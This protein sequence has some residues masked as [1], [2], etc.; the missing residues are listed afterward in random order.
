M[1]DRNRTQADD[2]QEVHKANFFKALEQLLIIQLA[3]NM[4]GRPA[5]DLTPAK[6]IQ[7]LQTMTADRPDNEELN[8][9]A[10]DVTTLL[11]NKITMEQFEYLRQLEAAGNLEEKVLSIAEKIE[12]QIQTARPDREGTQDYS[13]MA[14]TAKSAEL[15]NTVRET[16]R[17]IA[18]KLQERTEKTLQP[19]KTIQ[20]NQ[21]AIIDHVSSIQKSISE[22]IAKS[23]AIKTFKAAAQAA[24]KS[25][26]IMQAAAQG[27]KAIQ[28]AAKGAAAMQEVGKNVSETIQAV[29]ERTQAIRDAQE[30]AREIL[31]AVSEFINSEKY[32]TLKQN[33][34]AISDYIAEHKT[35]LAALADAGP[36]IQELVPFL[37]L[38][39]ET[40]QE[41]N[42]ELLNYTV[43]DILEQGIDA[44]GN[45]TESPF[46]NIIERAKQS[47]KEYRAAEETVTEVEKAAE[48]LP[49]IVANPT[50]SLNLP[51]DKPNSLIWNLI[52]DSAKDNPDG[53]IKLAIDTS[54]T[55]SKQ[56]AVI[57]Y[58]LSFDELPTDVKI[59]KRLTLFDKRAYMAAAALYDAGNEIITATQVYKLMG[60][61]TPPNTTDLQKVNDSLTKMGA[62]RLYIDN[63]KEVQIHKRYM[64]FK[65]DAP[66]LP[67]ERI[68]AY[69][70]GQLTESAIRLF[71]EPP[72]ISFAKQRDQ[73]TP[74]SRE[75]LESPINKTDANMQIDDYLLV[76]IGHM[77]SG[78]GKAPRKML[79]S[80]IYDRCNIKT[81]KQ[82]QRAPQKIRVYLDHYKKC[83]WIKGY[84]EGK[85]GITIQL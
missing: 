82:K 23:E 69:I 49:R 56:D 57:L 55:G 79:F 26:E 21:R 37:R 45:P 60:N 85:D 78:K 39:L 53:Q 25:R 43:F 40:E 15:T 64:H 54:K 48:E 5:D 51:V 33:I 12:Q 9:I 80:T 20:D 67:F 29:K 22:E 65:Y 31:N 28:E 16:G 84:T 61:T 68:S 18:G 72:L 44:E 2:A 41:Q 14:K 66:L 63:Q 73:I 7:I 6:A 1:K 24:E 13:L 76:R 50:D 8:R 58:N 32:K 62:A 35:E 38:E 42:P 4:A 30:R 81:K 75:L 19:I 36:E 71:R 11:W 59:T 77:K 3:A 83:G 70:N 17:I 47:L 27:A 52:T 34:T 74:I 10:E 46:K